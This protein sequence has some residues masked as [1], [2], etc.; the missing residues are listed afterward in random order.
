MLGAA[1]DLAQARLALFTQAHNSNPVPFLAILIFWLAI[2][3]TS[4][5]LFVRSSPVVIVTFFVGALSVACAIFLI[6]K[7]ISLLRGYCR[8]PVSRCATR[9]HPLVPNMKAARYGNNCTRCGHHDVRYWHKAGVASC[10]ANV[11]Y[12]G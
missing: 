10:T 2:I 8:F 11:R 3:F 1:V 5:G 9:S 4:F 12:W 6:W 7:W